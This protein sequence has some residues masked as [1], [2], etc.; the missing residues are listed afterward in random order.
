MCEVKVLI[1]VLLELIFYF[2]FNL[3]LGITFKIE[4]D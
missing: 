4:G 3:Q 1:I 2:I